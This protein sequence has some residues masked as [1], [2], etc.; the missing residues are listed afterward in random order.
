[1]KIWGLT[2]GI[3]MGKSTVAQAFRR[4]GV[5]VFDA[6]ATVRR[7]QGPNGR[8]LPAVAAAF[9]GTVR[10]SRL[11]RAALR[12]IVLSD[13]AKLKTLERI[14]HPLVRA[15]QKRFTARARAAGHRLVVLDIPLL[16]EGGQQRE[17]DR[18]VVVS[19]PPEIQMARVLQRRQMT[20][21][22]AEAM[23]ALQMP[24]AEKRRLADVVIRTGLSR[25]HATAAIRR[26][27][28]QERKA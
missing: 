1:M 5:P 22:E 14:M 28:A 8:A 11:D 21:R 25:F 12:A 4:C 23:I 15:E 24:D 10:E 18:I 16:L 9:P 26:L 13:R 20:R 27:V 3:G 19:A 2:G 17:V 6:D 7:L